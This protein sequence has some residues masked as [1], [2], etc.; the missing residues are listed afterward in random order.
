M[1]LGMVL[2]LVPLKSGATYHACG[3]GHTRRGIA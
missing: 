1:V 2:R 3:D